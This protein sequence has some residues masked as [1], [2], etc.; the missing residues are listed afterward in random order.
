[1]GCV[2]NGVAYGSKAVGIGLLLNLAKG[3]LGLAAPLP[4]CGGV[5]DMNKIQDPP[6]LRF[7]INAVN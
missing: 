7:V 5:V 3:L 6:E 4:V 2:I 1:V